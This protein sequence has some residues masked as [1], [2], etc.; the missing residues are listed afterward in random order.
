MILSRDQLP[1]A[2]DGEPTP[3][4]TIALCF[5]SHKSGWFEARLVLPGQVEPL[6]LTDVYDPFPPMLEWLRR[7]ARGDVAC[8]SID[9]EGD[10][11]D[12]AAEPTD[13]PGT[14]RLTAWADELKGDDFRQRVAFDVLISARTLAAALYGSIAAMW[15]QPDPDTFWR[16]WH[17]IDNMGSPPGAPHYRYDIRDGAIEAFLDATP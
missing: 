15:E 10:V 4:E 16:R 12:M 14:V 5:D 13:P 6:F 8:L 17:C 11:F 1:P 7:I 9:Q 2:P 3:V